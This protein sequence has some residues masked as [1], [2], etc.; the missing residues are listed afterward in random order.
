[1]I[2]YV[3]NESSVILFLKNT[4]F[5]VEKTDRKFARILKAFSLPKEEQEAAVLEIVKPQVVYGQNGFEKVGDDIYYQNEKLPL[6]L[7]NKVLSVLKDGLPIIHFE[8]FWE[9]LRNNPNQESAEQLIDFLSYRELPISEEGFIIAYKGVREDYFSVCGNPETIVI[10]GKV[11]KE[12]HILNSVGAKVEIERSQVSKNRNEGCH[13][14]SLHLGSL[15]YALNWGQKT[16]I[17]KVDPADVVSVPFCSSYQKC[18]VCKYEVIGEYQKEITDSVTSETGETLVDESQKEMT[19]TVQKISQYL[20]NRK[21]EGVKTTTVR[22]IQKSFSPKS[23]NRIDALA[24]L[25]E[26]GYSWNE[27]LE[28]KL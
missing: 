21:K 14:R 20:A 23:L 10:S 5:K 25:Q 16:V 27:N 11:D 24:A 4:P 26:L 12:G 6:P 17:V 13:S 15:D 7:K 2:S 1:M 8:K 28:I 3:I 9:R 18:R 22:K 19:A